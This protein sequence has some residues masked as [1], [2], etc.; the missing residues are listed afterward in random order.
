MQAD[1]INDSMNLRLAWPVVRFPPNIVV[2]PTHAGKLCST[3]ST[4]SLHVEYI[5]QSA[6]VYLDARARLV[7]SFVSDDYVTTFVS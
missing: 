1:C 3:L 7:S 5:G 4:K 2:I 6:Q